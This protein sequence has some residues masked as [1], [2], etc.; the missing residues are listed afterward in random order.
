M[1]RF[2]A[3]A[4]WQLFV[5]LLAF[6]C[7]ANAQ[8][9]TWHDVVQTV[10]IEADGDVLV[11]DERT[12]V[13]S[14][15]DFGEAFVE[16]MLAG[17]QSLT[18]LP[19]QSGAVSN[20]QGAT[21]YQN[22]IAGGQEVVVGNRSNRI[23]EARVRY[24]YRLE[25]TLDVYSDVVQWYWNTIGLED[26]A[27]RGYELTVTAP[28]AMNAPYDAFVHRYNN[29]EEPFVSLS[30]DRSTLTV[31]FERI[32]ASEGVEIRYLMDPSLFEQTS[33]APGL[34]NL[35]R[36]EARIAGVLERNR[37]MVTFRSSPWWAA[38]AVVVLGALAF[39]IFRTYRRVGREPDID[40]MLY[41]FEPPS[42]LAP[43]AVPMLLQQRHAGSSGAGAGFHATVMDLARRGYGEFRSSQGWFGTSKFGMVLHL[44]KDDS[45][46]LSFERDVLNYLKRA[47]KRNNKGDDAELEFD[48]LKSYSKTHLSKFLPTWG[49]RVRKHVEKRMGGSLITPE[50]R[51][52]ANRW[53]LI[54]FG[55]V[56]V[57]GLLAVPLLEV[58]RVIAIV[59][60]I[61]SFLLTIV[62]SAS[63]PA[64]RPEVAREVYAW[65][66]F[67][68]VLSD[69]SRMKDAPDDF[70]KLWDVYYCYAAAFGV[71]KKYLNNIQRAA[72]MRNIDERSLTRQAAWM[73]GDISS[74]NL[75]SFS[76][77]I[78]SL[79]SALTSASASAS[80]GGSSSGGGGGGG[81]R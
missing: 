47:A 77:S 27:V 1:Q 54:A 45:E 26:V 33:S 18:L 79:S 42:E 30:D 20:W 5:L 69:F 55:G 70:F 63:V 46:L 49:K 32:P 35:L 81:G 65:Q 21:A 57:F 75:S 3:Q 28:G 53:S 43:G 23:T 8:T 22:S 40:T 37:R 50:S 67:K 25:N 10:T 64:W 58:A 34:E 72:P 51:R 7:F 12:L 41:H 78:N 19:E 68:R 44:D 66:G 13:A 80:S 29:Q 61:A 11:S 62:V 16:V 71:A 56:V 52:A 6:F 9:Y 48:E 76:D 60:A 4:S 31:R 17:N 38:L 14:G 59:A 2:S 15:G 73:G 39:G 74:G 36:D 24:V